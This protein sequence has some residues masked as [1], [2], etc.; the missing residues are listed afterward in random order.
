[1]RG[2]KRQRGNSAFLEFVMRVER[3]EQDRFVSIE[4]AGA[5]IFGATDFF[6]QL[7]E[8]GE[9]F[10]FACGERAEQSLVELLNGRA[11]GSEHR[12]QRGFV[13]L[14]FPG[15]L[16][17]EC[18]ALHLGTELLAATEHVANV[19]IVAFEETRDGRLHQREARAR[20]N[21]GHA[22]ENHGVR[23]LR[24]RHVSDFGGAA[25]IG[26][27]GQQRVL[28]HR[29][30]QGAAGE[31]FGRLLNRGKQIGFGEGRA[32]RVKAP[33]SVRRNGSRRPSTL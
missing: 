3:V 1:M 20:Q 2:E 12:P 4:H 5:E 26:G 21:R 13:S 30:Q 23:D 32:A 7:G 18:F 29:A 25:E 33:S 27:S 28:N 17:R 10:L 8:D 16:V 22:S 6:L 14:E 19:E 24:L 9:D 15:Q 31:G 11:I